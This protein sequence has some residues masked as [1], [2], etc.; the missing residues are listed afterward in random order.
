MLKKDV[1]LGAIYVVKVS[2]HLTPVRI[3]SVS[4][5]GGWNGRNIRTGREI[6]IRSAQKL[7]RPYTPVQ[8]AAVKA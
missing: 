4:E 3:E 1:V 6:R 5:Y 7:R 2:G 8:D